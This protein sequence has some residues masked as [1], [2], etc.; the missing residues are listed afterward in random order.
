MWKTL[1]T[2]VDDGILAL[3]IERDDLRM[4]VDEANH[5]RRLGDGKTGHCRI[6]VGPW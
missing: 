6:K 1:G 3:R 2:W 5:S 4:D